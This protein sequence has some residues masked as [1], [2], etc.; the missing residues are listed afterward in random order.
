MKWQVLLL[1][2]V[3]TIFYQSFISHQMIALQ[4]LWKMFSISSK[5][6]FFFSKYLDFCFFIF[7]SF[8]PVSH[9]FRGWSKINL[10]V[11]DIINYLNKT[12]I[13]HFVWYFEKKKKDMTMEIL[14]IDRV[15]IKKHF[16]QKVMQ[17]MCTKS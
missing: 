16:Y 12:L 7:P 6:P 2:L 14:S 10:K 3:S 8:P 13:T 5:T 17:K 1:K 4:K 9:C 11:Y 15:L